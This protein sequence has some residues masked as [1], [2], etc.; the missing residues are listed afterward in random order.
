MSAVS[1]IVPPAGGNLAP[2]PPDPAE[3]CLAVVGGYLRHEGYGP[4][5]GDV[6]PA[7][8]QELRDALAGRPRMDSVT[9]Y[10]LGW[11][12]AE[13]GFS[14]FVRTEPDNTHEMGAEARRTAIQ[15]FEGIAGNMAVDRFERARAR[16]A[17][18]AIPFY[19]KILTSYPEMPNTTAVF[20]KDVAGA[21]ADLVTWYKRTQDP[22]VRKY[23][24]ALSAMTFINIG[25]EKGAQQDVVVAPAPSRFQEGEDQI[26]ERSDAELWM[27]FANGSH[28]RARIGQQAQA[29]Y[30]V[31]DPVFLAN[32]DFPGPDH[33]LGSA[34]A[35]IETYSSSAR[36][37][38]RLPLNSYVGA[39]VKRL[40]QVG[41]ASSQGLNLAYLDIAPDPQQLSPEDWYA[42]HPP[43]MVIADRR[44]LRDSVNALNARLRE[45][46]PADTEALG[47]MCIEMRGDL[48]RHVIAQQMFERIVMPYQQQ[49]DLAKSFRA[50]LAAAAAPLYGAAARGVTEM[51]PLITSC[52]TRLIDLAEGMLDWR[53]QASLDP[54]Q[55]PALDKLLQ[56][57]TVQLL[58][59][60]NNFLPVVSSPRDR[61]EYVPAERRLRHWDTTIFVA[62]VEGKF[63][64]ARAARFRMGQKATD[65]SLDECVYTVVPALLRAEPGKHPLLQAVLQEARGETIP[66]ATGKHLERARQTLG[67]ATV[68]ANLV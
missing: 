42:A 7:A 33:T 43:A 24:N 35:V 40:I 2:T 34:R 27:W 10:H 28:A 36:T 65:A 63:S 66:P 13:L 60:G 61:G 25:Y 57:M 44:T 55:A 16:I 48:Q 38:Q 64:L 50:A 31:F 17:A 58:L 41:K 29:G 19:L 8:R 54:A 5:F 67:R 26:A 9:D 62:D 21:M 15:I 52:R 23:I 12:C 32:T 46:S 53:G 18:A 49:G 37:V 39:S 1:E 11:A 47:W 68:V 59:L 30:V 45:L 51:E 56:E 6:Q 3:R 20:C 22:M 4:H 14:P